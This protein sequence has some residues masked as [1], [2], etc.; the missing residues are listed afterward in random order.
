MEAFRRVQVGTGRDVW[1]GSGGRVPLG[2]LSGRP[3]WAWMTIRRAASARRAA[4]LGS[5]GAALQTTLFLDIGASHACHC[6]SGPDKTGGPIGEGLGF[7]PAFVLMVCVCP[8]VPLTLT[9][10]P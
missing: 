4:V 6:D 7:G 10:H 3:S 8:Q 1:P 9:P 2:A 5:G